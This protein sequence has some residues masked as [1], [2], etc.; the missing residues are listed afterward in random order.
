LFSHALRHDNQNDYFRWHRLALSIIAPDL[1]ATDLSRMLGDV[2]GPNSAFADFLFVNGLASYWHDRVEALSGTGVTAR[3]MDAL[4]RERFAEAALYLHQRSALRELDSLFESA[5]ITYAVM[6]G[7]QVRELVYQDPALRPA[8]DIDIL[9]SLDQIE[10]ATQA[11]VRAGFELH[12]DAE[13]I[14]HEV[15]FTRASLAIDLHWNILRPGR[16]RSDMTEPMLCRRRRINGFWGLDDADTVFLMLVHPAF[17][18]Y[19]CSPNMGLIRVID[20]VLWLRQR[21]VDWD[22]IAERLQANGLKTAAWIVLQWFA[23]ILEPKNL[24]L[25]RTFLD[26][27]CPGPSRAGYLNYW[28]RNDLSTRWLSKPLLIQLGLTLMLHDRASD[29]QRAIA[30]WIEARRTRRLC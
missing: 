25:P 16:T 6:K 12:A 27:L 23:M 4:K 7:A 2:A 26:R 17:A 9:I 8:S 22:L 13:N 28:L 5:A 10:A 21:P 14:S 3:F 19:V 18:K 11:L 15:T 24:P 30:G 29:A 20:F 1:T